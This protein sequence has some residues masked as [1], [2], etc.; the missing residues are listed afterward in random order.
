[1]EQGGGSDARI[2]EQAR[3]M[4][5]PIPDKIKNRP[6]LTSGLEFY[7]RAFTE[8]SADRDIGMAE[9]HIPWTA[10]NQW[11][12]RHGIQ[13]DEFER[14]VSILR[15]VDTAYMEK[16]HSQHKKA[17]GKGGNKSFNKPKIGSK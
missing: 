1:M 5:M 11:A 2:I 10:M 14:F 6:Q 12:L 3:K 15:I 16:R 8:L 4:G 13:G 7:W 9:G 17:I